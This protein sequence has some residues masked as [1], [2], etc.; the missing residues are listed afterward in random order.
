MVVNAETVQVI[1]KDTGLLRDSTAIVSNGYFKKAA[2]LNGVQVEVDQASLET[3]SK[4]KK[5]KLTFKS[6]AVKTPYL[7]LLVQGSPVKAKKIVA[8]KYGKLKMSVTLP[9]ECVVGFEKFA[10][11]I[12]SQMKNQGVE[13]G[14]ARTVVY[15]D[16]NDESHWVYAEYDDKD[17][18]LGAVLN[19]SA[20]DIDAFNSLTMG[21]A[22]ADIT[23]GVS[24]YLWVNE[25]N[26]FEYSVKMKIVNISTE[27]LQ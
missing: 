19:G 23:L 15:S 26:A 2:E 6:G 1:S 5:V 21:I 20:F 13:V 4:F 27:S 10:L 17:K 7:N 22:T 9:A 8:D 11:Y 18:Y 25:S 14:D 16:K 24:V 12:H 3:G